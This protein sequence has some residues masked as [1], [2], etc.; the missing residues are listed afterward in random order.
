MISHW[1]H[2]IT[3]RQCHFF[4]WFSK[5]PLV[6][7]YSIRGV[8]DFYVLF[9]LNKFNSFENILELPKQISR[10]ICR[11]FQVIRFMW[12]VLLFARLMSINIE[13]FTAFILVL[14]EIWVAFTPKWYLFTLNFNCIFRVLITVFSWFQCNTNLLIS[15]FITLLSPL[16]HF[17]IILASAALEDRAFRCLNCCFHLYVLFLMYA[18]NV[19]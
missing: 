11:G 8:F 6:F 3:L 14:S 2:S 17:Y 9:T 15:R 10:P 1:S 13:L 7:R 18:N 16:S 19:H 12:P 4:S 5:L